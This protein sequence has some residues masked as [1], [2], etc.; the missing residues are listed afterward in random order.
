MGGGMG[1][2]LVEKKAPKHASEKATQSSRTLL[3]WG[4]FCFKKQGVSS[5][6]LK[7]KKEK[8][9]SSSNNYKENVGCHPFF[10]TFRNMNSFL[11]IQI[12]KSSR[13]RG[14]MGRKSKEQK[15]TIENLMLRI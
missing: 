10:N 13:A 6:I 5:D 2:Q 9:T 11:D 7:K 15:K 8:K 4:K 1:H 12:F 14:K 3:P